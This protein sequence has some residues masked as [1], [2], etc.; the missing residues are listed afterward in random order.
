MPLY[1]FHLDECGTVITD[2]EGTE[3]ADVAAATDRAMDEAREIMSAEIRHGKLCLGCC[4]VIEGSDG[5]EVARVH[6]RDAVAI[7][8]I[9]AC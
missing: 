4:I 2:P 9:T 1:F 6:F 8:G 5:A 3:M 7:S